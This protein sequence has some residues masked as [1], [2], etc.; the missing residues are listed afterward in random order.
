MSRYAYKEVEVEVE[1]ELADVLEFIEYCT[2]TN[3]LKQIELELRGYSANEPKPKE[4]LEDSMVMEHL[5]NVAK[6]KKYSLKEIEE[7]LPL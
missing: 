2:D 3:K 5:L 6:S 7:K 4:S 1:I